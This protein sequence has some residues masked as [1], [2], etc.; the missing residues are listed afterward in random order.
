MTKHMVDFD[1]LLQDNR[2]TRSRFK[3][4]SMILHN[5]P[6]N[7]MIQSLFCG[8]FGYSQVDFST[9]SKKFA[10]ATMSDDLGSL[11]GLERKFGLSDS[12]GS[13]FHEY[14]NDC[15]KYAQECQMETKAFRSEKQAANAAAESLLRRAQGEVVEPSLK[16]LVPELFKRN[17]PLCQRTDFKDF[18]DI[19]E[20]DIQN[21]KFPLWLNQIHMLG[22]IFGIGYYST[23]ENLLISSSYR[24]YVGRLG[25]NKNDKIRIIIGDKSIIAGANMAFE[26]IYM[27]A[28]MTNLMT[29]SE[30]E[31]CLGRACRKGYVDHPNGS[32]YCESFPDVKRMFSNIDSAEVQFIEPFVRNYGISCMMCMKSSLIIKN[33]IKEEKDILTN[34]EKA[35]TCKANV[36]NALISQEN[37]RNQ[38]NISQT[39]SDNCLK[40][41]AIA[42]GGCA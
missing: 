34:Q 3:H 18:Q 42:D 31:Q 14:C 2:D 8:I 16:L 17:M 40:K 27:Y 32:C 26:S 28:N 39:F 10:T 24:T 23:D 11:L 35:N 25:M 37:N 13:I 38:G 22:L 7:K 30:M 9:L 4:M 6:A 36:Q 29:K 41:I 19:L 33:K 21:N 15:V 12:R 20:S 5:D 1:A